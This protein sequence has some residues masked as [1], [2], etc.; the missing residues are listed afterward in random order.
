MIQPD[1]LLNMFEGLYRSM[2][3]LYSSLAKP[4]SEVL[5]PGNTSSFLA[6]LV[7][8]VLDAIGL[9]SPEVQTF[10][11]ETTLISFI[12]GGSITIFIAITFIKWLK[13]TVF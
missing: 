13:E 3:E 12:L 4:I 11:R 8:F 1:V 2:T 9:L 5:S 10:I 6:Q 7:G